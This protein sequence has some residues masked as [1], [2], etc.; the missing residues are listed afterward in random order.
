M[1]LFRCF[2]IVN[3]DLFDYV[4]FIEMIELSKFW[5]QFVIYLNFLEREKK[6]KNQEKRKKKI[7]FNGVQYRPR[8]YFCSYPSLF[9][10]EI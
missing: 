2:I 1:K 10:V 9:I 8:D 4:S 3:N 6:Q 7:K 5:N